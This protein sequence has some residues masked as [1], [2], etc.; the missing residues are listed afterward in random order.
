[1]ARSS[2]PELYQLWQQRIHDQSQSE[3]SVLEFCKLHN[4][5]PYNF[6]FWR[7]KL[8]PKT[9]PVSNE[10]SAGLIPVRIIDKQSESLARIKFASGATLDA[11]SEL[12]RIA[13]DQILASELALLGVRTC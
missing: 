6:Y 11:S 4:L 13:I 5:Q 9:E 3:L 7:R 12:M 8:A 1:M 2:S 10:S